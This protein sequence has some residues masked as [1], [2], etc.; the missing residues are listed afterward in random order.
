[1]TFEE[2]LIF[3]FF[4]KSNPEKNSLNLQN[5]LKTCEGIVVGCKKGRSPGGSTD[6][7]KQLDERIR[8]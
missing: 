4:L 1:M 8:L 7:N 3:F 5:M 6:E 2:E